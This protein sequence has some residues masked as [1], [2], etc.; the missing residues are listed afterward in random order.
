MS[1]FQFFSKLFLIDF[2]KYRFSLLTFQ[3]GALKVLQQ[4]TLNSK[5][6]RRAVINMGG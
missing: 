4:L 3:V 6:N 2:A 1:C 5:Y